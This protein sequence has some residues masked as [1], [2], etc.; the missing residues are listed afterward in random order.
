MKVGKRESHMLN[1]NTFVQIYITTYLNYL[2][3]YVLY[4][5]LD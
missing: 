5:L 3:K 1:R 2:A 4:I